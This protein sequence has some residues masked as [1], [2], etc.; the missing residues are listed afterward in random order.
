M[1]VV[2]VVTALVVGAVCGGSGGVG[3]K[4]RTLRL[5]FE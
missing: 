4:E 3:D 1:V 2:V 5:R